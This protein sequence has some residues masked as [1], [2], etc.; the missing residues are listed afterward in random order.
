MPTAHGTFVWYELMT[1]DP[2]G[3]ER[4]YRSVL[5]WNARDAGMP[6]MAYTLLSAGD[7][8]VAGLMAQPPDARAAG[9]PPGWIGYIAVDDV[10]ASAGHVTANGGRLYCPP[11]DIPGVGRFATAAD[12]Q[13]AVF[14]LFRGF[15]EQPKAA[16]GTPGHVGW[17]ELSALDW[18]GVFGF[19]A[20]LAGWTKGDAFPMP[21]GVYQ[22]FMA[23]GVPIGGMMNKPAEAPVPYWLYYFTVADIDAATERVTAGGGQVIFGPQPVPGDGWIVQA[24]DP[25]GALFALVGRRK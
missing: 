8:P 6:T 14:S 11:T 12:P 9:A 15:M 2:A 24:F 13:G 7:I 5:D 10:D 18:E 3:A 16:D 20:G 21:G 19:Y 22:L 4:F 25:Q 17:H 23:G 1:T